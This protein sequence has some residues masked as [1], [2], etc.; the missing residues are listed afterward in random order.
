MWSSIFAPPTRREVTISLFGLCV[1]VLA[2]NLDSSLHAPS[3]DVP[4]SSSPAASNPDL[5]LDADLVLEQDGRR[6]AGW[7]DALEDE[8]FGT[9]AWPAGRVA[10]GIGKPPEGEGSHY[11]DDALWG[12]RLRQRLDRG[13]VERTPDAEDLDKAG[14][15]PA[16]L[17]EGFV[18]WE[19][20][21]PETEVLTHT[22]GTLAKILCYGMAGRSDTRRPQDSQC[23]KTSSSRRVSCTSSR[24]TYQSF[25]LLRRLPLPMRTWTQHRETRTGVILRRPRQKKG[26]AGW[27]PCTSL[28]QVND[29]EII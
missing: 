19:G 10:V 12:E 5:Y 25:L 14:W 16:S 17:N 8:I 18:R 11:Q 20:R 7:R 27:L 22:P 9:W 1:F 4:T 15:G 21:M 13:P 24:I 28:A 6:P 3:L 2:Y 23:W 26:S 29:L